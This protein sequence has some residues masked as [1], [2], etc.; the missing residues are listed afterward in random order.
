MMEESTG[1]VV[2]ISFPIKLADLGKLSEA[3]KS[4][5]PVWARK[6]VIAVKVSFECSS[7]GGKKTQV[8]V[9][10]A[11]DSDGDTVTFDCAYRYGWH[12]ADIFRQD[13]PTVFNRLVELAEKRQDDI[14]KRPRMYRKK[15]KT[16]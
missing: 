4:K 16:E 5:L 7:K 15:K 11:E 13:C 12:T 2:A 6:E 14:R 1:S 9:Q 3:E 10:V 8:F